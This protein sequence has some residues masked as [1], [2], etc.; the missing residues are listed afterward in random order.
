MKKLIVSATI[1]A[2]AFA[3][4]ADGDMPAGITAIAE[5]TAP[6]LAAA[7]IVVGL[8]LLGYRLGKRIIPRLVS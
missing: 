1:L 8:T 7:A 4:A 2:P 3:F 6:A 5:T